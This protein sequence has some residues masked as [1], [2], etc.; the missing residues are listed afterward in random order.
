[1]KRMRIRKRS[2]RRKSSNR[3]KNQLPKQRQEANPRCQRHH[4]RL[5]KGKPKPKAKAKGSA[6]DKKEKKQKGKKEKK[7]KKEDT[8]APFK[9]P[10]AKGGT[11][12]QVSKLQSGVPEAKEEVEK[13]EGEEEKE[14]EEV[15]EQDECVD[16]DGHNEKRSK[17]AGG[18]STGCSKQE[19]FQ[20]RSRRSAKN[21]KPRKKKPCWWTA[22]YKKNSK[23]GCWEMRRQSQLQKLAE[24]TSDKSFGK[25][26]QT[27]F[28]RAIM[29]HHYFHG[30][31]DAFNQALASGDITGVNQG[32][33]VMYR[34]DTYEVEGPKNQT[35]ESTNG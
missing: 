16:P 3:L 10:A 19:K 17:G 34:F 2:K 35:K 8:P 4:Q 27:S 29:L 7:N 25:D 18:S 12:D 24:E 11:R 32:G 20:H 33:K 14:E 22:G 31:A 28:P 26:A 13:V 9:R 23:T 21:M 6:K 30:D 5:S 15:R 1:M